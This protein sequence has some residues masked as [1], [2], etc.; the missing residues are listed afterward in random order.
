MFEQCIPDMLRC[1]W[2]SD[3]YEQKNFYGTISCMYCLT[4]LEKKRKMKMETPQRGIADSNKCHI[5]LNNGQ[6]TE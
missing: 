4:L 3:F 2:I 5:I 6:G 1:S